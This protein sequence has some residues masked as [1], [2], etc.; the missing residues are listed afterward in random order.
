MQ[1]LAKTLWPLWAVGTAVGLA[2]LAWQTDHW[3]GVRDS[4]LGIEVAS[5]GAALAVLLLGVMGII[6]GGLMHAS[7]FFLIRFGAILIVGTFIGAAVYFWFYLF[8]TK[9][10]KRTAETMR[11]L[12]I[13]VLG[14]TLWGPYF[15]PNVD[16][17]LGIAHFLIAI[18]AGV[19]ASGQAVAEDSVARQLSD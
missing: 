16:I 2:Y 15:F 9:S 11:I 6:R 17:V 1:D 5:G 3:P 10:K 12:S 8:T 18:W 19:T 13:A 4:S 14:I 7:N